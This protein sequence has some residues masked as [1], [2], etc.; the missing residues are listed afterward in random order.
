MCVVDGSEQACQQPAAIG[1]GA[2]WS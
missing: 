1:V 2:L